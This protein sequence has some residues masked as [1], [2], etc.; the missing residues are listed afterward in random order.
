[1]RT[2]LI[3]SVILHI[4]GVVVVSNHYI[5]DHKK[6]AAGDSSSYRTFIHGL[7]YFSQFIG[8][9]DDEYMKEENLNL[10]INAD[11]RLDLAQRSMMEFEHSMSSTDLDMSGVEVILTSIEEMMF[12]EMSTY[13][14]NNNKTSHFTV[15]QNSINHL[16]EKLPETYESHQ[17]KE[18]I[19]LINNIHESDE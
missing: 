10:L 5:A 9:L 16:L 18:F 15:M 7:E 12:N 3:I 17:K 11:E 8:E 2:I 4:F 19:H 6:H 1:L 13:A 14:L